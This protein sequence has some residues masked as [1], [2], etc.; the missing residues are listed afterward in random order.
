MDPKDPT[1]VLRKAGKQL[2][3]FGE[4]RDDGTTAC[5]CWIYCRL[6]DRGGQP[7]WPGATTPTRPASA[8]PQ[9]GVGVA[10]Q[11]AHPLQPRVVPI[12]NGKPWDPSRKLIEWN[13]DE[14]D[15]RRRAGLSSADD[16]AATS[17]GPVHHERGRR[18][19]P[20]RP[21]A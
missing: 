2:A 7:R 9:L 5:G 12:P 4:L 11:P 8:I 14:V 3:G 19:A 18:G 20:L 17:V 6:L 21:R 10:G 1:K 13:G 15:R 16:E